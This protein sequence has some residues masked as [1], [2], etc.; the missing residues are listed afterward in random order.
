MLVMITSDFHNNGFFKS[1]LF[2]NF[3]YVCMYF[4]G[5]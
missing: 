2:V 3:I 5:R 1:D 4:F